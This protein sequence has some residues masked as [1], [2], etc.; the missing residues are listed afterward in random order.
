MSTQ[1]II[2]ELPKLSRPELEQVDAHLHKLL[3]DHRPASQKSWGEALLEVAGSA[4][5]LPQ[6]FSHQHDYYLHGAGRR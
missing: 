1:E 5:G 2:A 4:K 6:D 3:E